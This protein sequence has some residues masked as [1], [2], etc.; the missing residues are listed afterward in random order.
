M[1]LFV[2]FAVTL[3]LALVACTR[4]PME[5]E[6]LIANLEDHVGEYVLVRAQFQ[7]AAECSLVTPDGEWMTYCGDCQYCRGPMV[8]DARS[9]AAQKNPLVVVGAYDLR[10]VRC[11]GKLNEVQCRPFE[12]GKT[13]VVDGLI[14]NERPRKLLVRKYWAE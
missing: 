6:A 3:G 5:A 2:R 14:A 11:E 9:E 10:A 1:K 8:V 7:S 12:P 4:Q 13:Y